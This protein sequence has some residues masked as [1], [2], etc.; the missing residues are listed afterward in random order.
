MFFRSALL[1]AG[2]VLLY[3]QISPSPDAASAAGSWHCRGRLAAPL[4][5]GER[6][7]VLRVP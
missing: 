3:G 5:G 7:P 1:I 6:D 4:P 2:S